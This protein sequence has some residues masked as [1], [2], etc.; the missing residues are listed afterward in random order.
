[1][2]WVYPIRTRRRRCLVPVAND[3]TASWLSTERARD[4]IKNETEPARLLVGQRIFQASYQCNSLNMPAGS[5]RFKRLI[6]PCRTSCLDT[7]ALGETAFR[8]SDFSRSLIFDSPGGVG[9]SPK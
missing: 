3:E 4:N 6:P 7:G 2:R 5:N 1:M 8:K 9:F